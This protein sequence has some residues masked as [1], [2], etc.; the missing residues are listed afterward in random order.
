MKTLVVYY[1]LEG[2]TKEAA[3]KIAAA[4]SADILPLI[5]V[6]EI[7]KKGLLKFLHGGAG[8]TKGKGTELQPYTLDAAEYDAIILG[9]PVWAGKP[10][11][12]MNQFLSD[13]K[14]PEKVLGAFAFAASGNCDK[15]LALL[16]SK[17]PSIRYTVGLAD[18]NSQKLAPANEGK[19]EKFI[20][21]LKGVCQ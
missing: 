20:S 4:L 9:T 15:C 1:S 3:E 2:N 11:M 5:P 17:L 10:S 7:P 12:A 21:D 19:I 16:Q 13:L 8:A 14:A 18:R 6:K